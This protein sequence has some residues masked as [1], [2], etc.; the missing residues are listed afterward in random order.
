MPVRSSISK[1]VMVP[2][3]FHADLRLHAVV[4][5]V[6]VGD[7]ASKPVATNFTGRFKSFDS[8]TVAISS[9]RGGP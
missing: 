8:A 7:E 5:G 1:A 2:S 6:N 3:F 4:A 9:D